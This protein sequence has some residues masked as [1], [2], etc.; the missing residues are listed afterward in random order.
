[1][2]GAAGPAAQGPGHQAEEVRASMLLHIVHGCTAV[3]YL[4]AARCRRADN[5]KVRTDTKLKNK[6][7]KREKKLLRAGFEGRR[8]TFIGSEK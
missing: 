6:R 1:M 3:P 5:L 7:D 4:A 2:E 8:D